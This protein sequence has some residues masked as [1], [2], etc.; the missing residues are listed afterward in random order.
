MSGKMTG[1]DRVMARD[2]MWMA[3][4]MLRRLARLNSLRR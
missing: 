4:E 3:E 1:I 2:D